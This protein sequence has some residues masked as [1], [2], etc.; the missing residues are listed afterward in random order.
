[1]SQAAPYRVVRYSPELRDR[2]IDL[3]CR[4]WGR[5]RRHSARYF[6]W[7]Y[8]DN[9]YAG[10][11]PDIY[12]VLAGDV[13]VGSRGFYRSRWESGLGAERVVTTLPVADDF[14]IEPAHRGRGLASLLMR[15]ALGDL[16]RRERYVLNLSGSLVTVLGSLAMGWRS[17][18]QQEPIGFGKASLR[19]RFRDYLAR[20][21]F[22]WRFG[23][24][25]WLLAQNERWPFRRLD[26]EGGAGP[27]T[28]EQTP[29]VAA[30]CEL[31]ER[32]GHDGRI[33]H[34]RDPEYLTWRYRC[35]LGSYRF[36]CY[37]S[38]PIEGCLVLQV[39]VPYNGVPAR[40]V[41]LVATSATVR[42]ALLER[43]LETGRFRRCFA[44]SATL[45]AD[46]VDLLTARGWHPIDQLARAHGGP[47]ILVK[48]LQGG[49][50]PKTWKLGPYSLTQRDSWDVRMIDTMAG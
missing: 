7:K 4:I 45:P 1:M 10:E 49:S 19:R 34:V 6:E 16:G 31:I 26:R 22:F 27:I 21:R 3:G 5:D 46:A 30:L 40:I 8:L 39:P 2:F 50:P 25:R 13:I 36:L 9:P 28:I 18:G 35:P 32:L 42:S 29:P 17:A 48:Q 41:E 23:E 33:R 38:G 15:E 24:S 14:Y 12:L 47:C 11:T 20:R 43:A 37:G 44:W